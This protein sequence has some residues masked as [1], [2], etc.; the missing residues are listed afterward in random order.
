MDPNFW[1]NRW[2][3]NE[4]GFHLTEANPMLVKYFAEL[5]LA[6]GDRMFLPLCGKTLDIGWMISNGYRVAG[7]EL[8]RI[9]IEQL[10]EELGIEPRISKDGGMEH[11]QGPNIDIFVGD[12]FNLTK[13]MLGRV[14]AVY[15]RAALVA[16]PTGMRGRYTAHVMKITDDAPQLL[17]CCEYDQRLMEGP[18][19]SISDEEV[20]ER[21][22]GHFNLSLLG[23][24]PGGLTRLKGRSDAKENVWLLRK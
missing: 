24:M 3:K 5:S 7:A 16:L 19:F 21:Y 11:Y 9:A 18:P 23:T 8:S 22:G 12:I 20:K 17:I 4:T 2:A 13:E 6:R 14:D 10:F 1:F 15:D